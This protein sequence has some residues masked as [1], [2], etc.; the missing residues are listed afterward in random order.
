[1]KTSIFKFADLSWESLT[2]IK[3][4]FRQDIVRDGFS[5]QS[6]NNNPSLKV[7]EVT[8]SVG[9][10]IAFCPIEPCF[11]V[12]QIVNPQATTIEACVAGDNADRALARLAQQEGITRFLIICPPD[13]PS[14]P[15]ERWVRIIERKVSQVAAMQSVDCAQSTT[16][17]IN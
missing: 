12:N 10:T 9:Q 2:K 11:V 1:M 14:Q 3:K 15:D 16:A 17:Y 6:F 5:L 7:V 13:Y 8:N 4:W